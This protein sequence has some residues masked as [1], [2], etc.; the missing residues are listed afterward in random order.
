VTAKQEVRSH[1][2]EN[3]YRQRACIDWFGHPSGWQSAETIQNRIRG[4]MNGRCLRAEIERER[5][6]ARKFFRVSGPSCFQVLNYATSR[7]PD[8]RKA[9]RGRSSGSARWTRIE[10]RLSECCPNLSFWA[11]GP[12]NVSLIICS[13]L[14][15]SQ[16]LPRSVRYL[17]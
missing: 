12:R 13:P 1:P 9:S 2:F 15:R 8:C 4:Q 10:S 3:R 5:K 6:T 14:R 16:W 11:C 7:F 17:H